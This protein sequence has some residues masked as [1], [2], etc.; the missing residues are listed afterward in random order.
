MY[1]IFND[2]KEIKKITKKELF[3]KIGRVDNYKRMQY[4]LD[5]A[6]T[7]TPTLYWYG[8]GQ[9]HVDSDNS[10]ELREK[11]KKA[12][13]SS[14]PHRYNLMSKEERLFLN[15]LPSLV[16]IYRGMT[17]EELKSGDFGICW[18][19]SK[20][21]ANYFAFEYFKNFS[22]NHLK[23]VVHEIQINKNDAI[24]YFNEKNEQEIIY[25]PN[26]ANNTSKMINY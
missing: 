19:L 8:L 20:E 25:I 3:Y 4:F 13:L 9:A 11:I 6:P 24:A 10:Y 2:M 22:T 7:L 5:L 14:L 1:A 12:F 18:S 26:S 15:T 23:K 16:T 21:K 17:E